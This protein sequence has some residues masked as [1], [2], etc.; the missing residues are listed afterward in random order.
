[1]HSRFDTGTH[2]GEPERC[3]S[4]SGNNKGIRDSSVASAIS[5]VNRYEECALD[6]NSATTYSDNL[7]SSMNAYPFSRQC[8]GQIL[9]DKADTCGD[10]AFLQYQEGKELTY[11]EVNETANRIANGLLNH[12][13]KKGDKVA[14]FLPNCLGA[15]HLWFGVSKAGLVD[16]PINLANK[17]NFLSYILNNS[18]SK[19]IVIDRGLIDRLKLIENDLTKL[20]KV[21]VWPNTEAKQ[22]T[23]K[24]RFELSDYQDLAKG[25]PETP[26]VATKASDPQMIIYTSGTTGPAKG[27]MEPHS[28]VYFSAREYIDAI[29]ATSEDILY[30]CLPLFHANARILCVYPALLL[31]AKAVIYERFSA[32]RFWDQIRKAKATVFNSLGATA[33]F[34]YSQPRKAN[35]SDNPV[36][37]CAAFPMPTAIYQDFE[38]RYDLKIVEGYGLTELAI[39]TYNPYDRPKI[40]SCGRATSSFEIRIV[41]DDDFPVPAGTVGEIVAQGRVPWTTSLGYYNMPDKTVELVRN[42]FYH[43]GDAGYLDEEGYLFFVDRIKD[44]IRR[45]G[46]NISSFEVERSV[47]AHSQVSESAAIGVRSEEAEDEVKIVVVLKKGEQLAPEELLAFCEERM[48]YFAVPRYVEFV[49]NLPKTPT[50]KVEKTKLRERGITPDAWDREKT[51]YKLKK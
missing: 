24:L 1:M 27:C 9:E 35:D 44:Y 43:T 30:T 6:E 15:V 33:N 31:G 7:E 45:R 42:H 12:G 2:E 14:T 29:G 34:I 13:L 37:V 32:S 22:G 21:I 20:E 46:E 28:M 50:G 4:N 18:D 26:L 3:A 23:P 10:K 5:A 8:L 16:V 38:K 25:S 41:D 51:G 17:G 48:P 36:R 49:Q 19:V 40:G 11:R 39:I 47:N